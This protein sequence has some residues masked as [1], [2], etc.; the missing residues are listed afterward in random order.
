MTLTVMLTQLIYVHNQNVT[1][2]LNYD[3]RSF[4]IHFKHKLA[5]F[6]LHDPAGQP[7]KNGDKGS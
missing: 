7:H 3:F 4:N 1:N 5:W 2:S 6:G